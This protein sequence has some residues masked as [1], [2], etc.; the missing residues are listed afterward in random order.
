[1]NSLTGYML[2]RSFSTGGSGKKTAFYLWTSMP[3]IGPKA[4]ELKQ[5]LAIPKGTP[6]RVQAFDGLNIQKILVGLR[7]SAAISGKRVSCFLSLLL[8]L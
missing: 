7:H 4:T 1:M 8:L 6:Q 3:K 2:K 5:Q